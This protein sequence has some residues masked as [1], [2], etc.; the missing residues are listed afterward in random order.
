MLSQSSQKKFSTQQ[1]NLKKTQLAEANRHKIL[2][3]KRML[4][5]AFQSDVNREVGSNFYDLE[6]YE[7]EPT[8]KF[9]PIQGMRTFKNEQL[10]TFRP[11]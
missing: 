10:P 2:E 9:P 7:T 1:F 4:N 5:Y 8:D 3:L 11:I 6:N